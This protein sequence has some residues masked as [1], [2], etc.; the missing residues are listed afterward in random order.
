MP[1]KRNLP[2]GL[3]K[4]AEPAV[5]VNILAMNVRKWKAMLAAWMVLSVFALPR[6]LAQSPKTGAPAEAKSDV[7]YRQLVIG[8]WEDHYSGKRTMT[9]RTNGTALMV[10]ELSGLKSFLYASRLEFDMVWSIENGRMKKRTTGGRPS[11]RVNAIL[12]MMGDHVEEPI[13]ELTQ[14]RLLLL[15]ENGKRK[16]D[17][18]RVREVPPDADAKK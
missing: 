15:D 9:V 7:E 6:V 13:L 3:R 16:Y 2:L 11:G 8:T 1:A 14:D 10:V 5:V 12:K 4:L 18:Q 17:W